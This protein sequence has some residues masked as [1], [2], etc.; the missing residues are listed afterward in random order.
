MY[1][2]VN[3]VAILIAATAFAFTACE[4]SG[5]QAMGPD[6]LII[7]VADSTEYAGLEPLLRNTFAPPFHTPQPEN[8]FNLKRIDIT[9]LPNYKRNKNI[10]FIAPLEGGSTV[11]E[12]L[13]SALDSTVKTLVRNREEY[14]FA[15]K[16][17]WFED[18]TVLYLTGNSMEEIETKLVTEQQ[19]LFYFFKNAWDQREK[20]RM[21]RLP[22][23]DDLEEYLAE[24]HGF[25]FSIIKSWFLAKDSV[26]ISSVLLRRQAPEETERWL[27]IHW[28]DS[29]NTDLLTPDFLL[30]RRNKLTNILYRTVDDKA[31]VRVDTAHYLQWDEVNFNGRFAW[32]MQGLWQMSD[33]SMGGPFVSYLFYDEDHERIYLLDGSV[34]APKYKKKKL[35]Q[36]IDIMM[37]TFRTLELPSDTTTAS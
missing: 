17:Q 33:Y 1:S 2:K 25:S 29:K 27:L 13:N 26:E 14:V 32:R 3:L 22:R 6:D 37:H 36:D 28:I 5:Q 4:E 7:V 23:E 16:N 21:M 30:D 24:N 9:E 34:F 11:G 10:V 31:Y 8:W 20:M 19:D 15:K 18:Q 12:F 35:I